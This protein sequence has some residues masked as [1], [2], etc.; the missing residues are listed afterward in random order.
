VAGRVTHLIVEVWCICAYL[1]VFVDFTNPICGFVLDF[2]SIMDR[3]I[4]PDERMHSVLF[5]GLKK[6]YH[7]DKDSM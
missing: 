3:T 4:S 6:S 5:V 2:L 7:H 1:G